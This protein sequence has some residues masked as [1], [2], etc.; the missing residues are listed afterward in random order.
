MHVN[1]YSNFITAFLSS[2]KVLD[3]RLSGFFSEVIRGIN[4]VISSAKR[5]KRRSVIALPLIGPNTG[6]IN[7]IV[8]E[9]VK[10]NIVLVASAGKEENQ[11]LCSLHLKILVL[12]L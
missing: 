10:E 9:A 5:T 2:I 12:F 4:Y 6:A 8:E 3:C 11:H 1:M 7:D